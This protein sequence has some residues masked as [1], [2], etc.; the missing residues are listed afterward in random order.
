MESLEKIEM[1]LDALVEAARH[2][3]CCG[4]CK[5]FFEAAYT[6][7]ASAQVDF[8]QFRPWGL[9]NLLLPELRKCT[10]WPKAI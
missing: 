6:T 8:P 9:V 2:L 10:E 1:A 3:R 4:R 7:V 5:R